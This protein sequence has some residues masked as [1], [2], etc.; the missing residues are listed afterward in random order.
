MDRYLLFLDF[1]SNITSKYCTCRDAGF[2]FG[3][4]DVD[5]TD[6]DDALVKVD[7]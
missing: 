4:A 5:G 3:G 7:H 2:C 1:K 6:D